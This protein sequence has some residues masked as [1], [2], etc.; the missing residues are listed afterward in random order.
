M[1]KMHVCTQTRGIR[2]VSVPGI[3]NGGLRDWGDM[4]LGM[5]GYAGLCRMYSVQC[6]GKKCAR[7]I[8]ARMRE[9]NFQNLFCFSFLLRRKGYESG[10]GMR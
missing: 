1:R 9:A 7:I 8:H 3:C 2:A 10:G 4:Y 5:D 6:A